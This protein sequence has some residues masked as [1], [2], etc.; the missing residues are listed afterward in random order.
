MQDPDGE[1]CEEEPE[2]E[3]DEQAHQ[4][5]QNQAYVLFGRFWNLPFFFP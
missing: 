3:L 5:H 1:D 4:A 2:P